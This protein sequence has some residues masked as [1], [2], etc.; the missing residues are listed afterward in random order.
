MCAFVRKHTRPHLVF[1]AIAADEAAALE[2]DLQQ[3]LDASGIVVADP[4]PV[5]G[6]GTQ[7]KPGAPPPEQAPTAATTTFGATARALERRTAT[8]RCRSGSA[9]RRPPATAGRSRSRSTI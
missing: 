7:P 8:T 6:T 4:G 5:R 1:D 2:R 3:A 9:T